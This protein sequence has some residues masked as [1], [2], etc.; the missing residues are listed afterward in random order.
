MADFCHVF[1]SNRGKWRDQAFIEGQM[2]PSPLLY[3]H[4][5]KKK[6]IIYSMQFVLQTWG[7]LKIL[8]FPG[9]NRKQSVVGGHF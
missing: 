6:K 7:Q 5:S 3:H 8:S 9:P 1:P 2:P 4:L